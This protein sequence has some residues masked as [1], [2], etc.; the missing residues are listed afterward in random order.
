MT[1]SWSL[2]LKISPASE[3]FGLLGTEG[4]CMTDYGDDASKLLLVCTTAWRSW[5]WL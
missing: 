4:V 5:V 3:T 2:G 1:G